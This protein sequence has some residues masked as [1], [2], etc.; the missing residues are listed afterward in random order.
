MDEYILTVLLL[1]DN[2]FHTQ[3]MT[4]TRCNM[5]VFCNYFTNWYLR[6]FFIP[7]WVKSH[8][9]FFS[10][11]L[12]ATSSV[13]AFLLITIVVTN[14]PSK[15][16]ILFIFYK[17][18]V[19]HRY[20]RRCRWCANSLV[21]SRKSLHFISALSVNYLLCLHGRKRKILICAW[22]DGNQEGEAETY[23]MPKIN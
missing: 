9:L 8:S 6:A 12:T 20:L 1:R 19:Y 21:I 16:F 14:P 23:Q 15:R 5:W 10:L 7:F 22:R 18:I 11:L 2:L 13:E 17:C 3:P 4:T